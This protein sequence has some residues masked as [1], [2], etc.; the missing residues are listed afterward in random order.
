MKYD[1][2]WEKLQNKTAEKNT[3]CYYFTL[4]FALIF[5]LLE[6]GITVKKP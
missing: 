6:N 2:S 5:E 3:S 4:E 1:V